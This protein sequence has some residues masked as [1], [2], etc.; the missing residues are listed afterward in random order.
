MLSTS[1]NY[2]LLNEEAGIPGLD[3]EWSRLW[4]ITCTLCITQLWLQ[5][6][7]VVHNGAELT[8]AGAVSRL[9][10]SMIRHLTA[11]A[12]RERRHL[13]TKLRGT[14]LLLCIEQLSRPPRESSQSGWGSR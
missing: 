11:H 9:C 8:V 6:N 14:R 7:N 1:R 10:S 2:V 3:R 5:R 13:H 4:W 12:I